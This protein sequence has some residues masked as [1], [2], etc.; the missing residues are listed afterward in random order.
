MTVKRRPSILCTG[1]SGRVDV[2]AVAAARPRGVDLVHR[3]GPP[4]DRDHRG[5]P[6]GRRGRR[7]QGPLA[8]H[9]RTRPTRCRRKQTILYYQCQPSR[10]RGRPL[11]AGHPSGVYLAEAA[12][13]D[14]VTGFLAIA[15]YGKERA[16]YWERVLAAADVPDPAA[17]AAPARQSWSAR[18]P[19]SR[20]GS[21]GRCWRWRTSRPRRKRDSRS[22]SASPNSAATSLRASPRWPSSGTRYPH[23]RLPTRS[24]ARPTGHA[25]AAR[26]RLARAARRAAA[27]VAGEPAPGDPL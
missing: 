15:V 14:G 2:P 4:G 24:R 10:L 21:A 7:Q 3:A 16:S 12:L 5:V 23:R 26:R 11:P 27:R 18:S 17:P 13:L 9:I 1:F 6:A 19:T 22:P 25:A 20:R 8:A